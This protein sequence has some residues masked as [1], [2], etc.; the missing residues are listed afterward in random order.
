MGA[1]PAG[2]GNNNAY[3]GLQPGDIAGW[4]SD[5]GSGH[6]TVYVGE[7]GTKFIDVRSEGEKPRKIGNGYGNGRPLYKSS[8]F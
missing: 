1:D 6:V 3:P 7:P 2:V 8:R 4:K 5:A